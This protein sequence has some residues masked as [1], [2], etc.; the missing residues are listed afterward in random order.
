MTNPIDEF[1]EH[2][3]KAASTVA[4]KDVQM[5]H[6]WNNNGRTTEDSEK[7]LKQVDPVIR[8]ATNVYSGKVNIPKTAIRAEFQ[9]Q[10][11]K[12]F[13]KYDPNKGVQLN[14]FLTGQLKSGQRF[15]TTYQNVGHIPETRIYKI[16]EF[17]TAKDVLKDKLGREPSAIEMADHLKWPIREVSA[18]ELETSRREIPLSTLEADMS[19]IKPSE[20]AETLRLLQYDL[21]PE[22]RAVYEYLVGMNGKPQLSPGQ[23]SQK[24]GISQSKISRIRTNISNK[25]QRYM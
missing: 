6:E 9:I 22:E 2:E 3:K 5:W 24:M 4:K 19:S 13:E 16:T 21:D 10:A 20:E 15:I 12:A 14:T 25:A 7:L 8:R 1:A 18:L 23:I 11:L 17:N